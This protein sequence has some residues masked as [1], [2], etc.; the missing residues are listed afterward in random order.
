MTRSPAWIRASTQLPRAGLGSHPCP[1]RPGAAAAAPGA[2][3]SRGCSEHAASPTPATWMPPSDAAPYL[4]QSFNGAVYYKDDCP[5]CEEETQHRP[6]QTPKIN[7]Q[8]G[9]TKR[10]KLQ[11]P[12]A[13]RRPEPWVRGLPVRGTGAASGGQRAGAAPPLGASGRCPG[14]H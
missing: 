12:P 5:P 10:S 13:A 3:W 2:A 7:S 8:L 11:L 1:R 9:E 14:E 4:I 6:P